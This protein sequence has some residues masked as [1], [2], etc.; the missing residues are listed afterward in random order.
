MT[1]SG[2]LVL[3]GA[4]SV[5]ARSRRPS[6]RP[7]AR[8]ASRRRAR[9]SC[10]ARTRAGRSSSAGSR[11]GAR[12]ASRA[13]EV[14]RAP[15][16]RRAGA[17]AA[18]ARSRGAHLDREE[19]LVPPGRP[20]ELPQL[21]VDRWPPCDP[22]GLRGDSARESRHARARTRARIPRIV[23]RA[24]AQEVG[25]PGRGGRTSHGDGDGRGLKP[26]ATRARKRVRVL[27]TGKSSLGVCRCYQFVPAHCGVQPRILRRILGR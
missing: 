16:R 24:V 2:R 1:K 7:R 18:R 11:P 14:A 23:G 19:A 17:R 21:A 9:S 27:V 26:A 12:A 8:R 20:V 6:A 4:T 22:R 13:R 25:F 5:S 10:A 15:W 3:V